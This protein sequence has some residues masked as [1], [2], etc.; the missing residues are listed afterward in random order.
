[1]I[2]ET[3]LKNKKILKNVKTLNKKTWIINRDLCVCSYWIIY[4]HS[5]SKYSFL[6]KTMTTR[7]NCY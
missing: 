5:I 3:T 4:I 7:I 2:K 1:M 6:F